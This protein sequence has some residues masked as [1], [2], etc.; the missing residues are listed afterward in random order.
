VSQADRSSD[1][2]ARGDRLPGL[3][4]TQEAMRSGDDARSFRAAAS[5]DPLAAWLPPAAAG[6]EAA[7][8]AVLAAV[9]PAVVAVV[10][11]ILGSG[12]GEAQDAVQESLVAVHAAIARFRGE[13]LFVAYARRIAA[14]T[15]LGT[16][17]RR[18]CET[19]DEVSAE[20]VAAAP[21]H[22]ERIMRERRLQALRALLDELPPGQAE[23][24]AMRVVLGCTLPEV[25]Q[26]TGAPVNTV[27]SR[28][29]L[30]REHI[31]ARIESDPR[32]V[33]LFELELLGVA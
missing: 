28:I 10:R 15:A 5:I 16:R 20:L 30:A 8:H 32:L 9:A 2:D 29:R 18:S 27:R 3:D 26:A 19:F 23:S 25:A 1:E 6:D 24:L 12:T 21:S 14:R 11:V 33:A 7:V 4:A 13:C 17:R 31:K 22:D